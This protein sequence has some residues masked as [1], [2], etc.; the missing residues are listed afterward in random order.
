MGLDDLER[1]FSFAAAGIAL[2]IAVVIYVPRLLKDTRITVTAKALK[3]GHCPPAYS[4]VHSVCSKSQLTH[5]SYWVTPFLFVV[6]VGAAI[7]VF[8]FVRKRPGVIVAAFLLGLASGIT[9]MGG[10]AFLALGAWLSVRAFRLNK[11]GD[12]SFRGANVKAREMAQARRA[13]RGART[14]ARTSRTSKSAAASTA[15]SR[16]PAPSKRY[17]PKKTN[18]R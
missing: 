13:S 11:Y 3:N 1:R 7:A 17:T 2:I 14:S 8:G 6:V 18:R 12:P 15:T 16:T 5:P 10:V 9:G 4:L